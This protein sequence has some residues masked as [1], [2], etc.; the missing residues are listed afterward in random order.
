M[1]GE[2]GEEGAQLLTGERRY[3]TTTLAQIEENLAAVAAELGV[4]IVCAQTNSEGDMVDLVRSAP[5]SLRTSLTRGV[6]RRSTTPAAS[7][8][9]S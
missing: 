8:E 7:E 4:K 2:E 5:H 1:R 3:G 9:S 6:D